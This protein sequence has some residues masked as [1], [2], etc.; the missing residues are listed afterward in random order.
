MNKELQEL[1]TLIKNN[2]SQNFDFC[3][4]LIQILPRYSI[5]TETKRFLKRIL[6]EKITISVTGGEKF[7][8]ESS[9]WEWR[10]ITWGMFT[11]KDLP[12]LVEKMEE[13]RQSIKTRESNR[14]KIIK[15]G[16]NKFL[17]PQKGGS[18]C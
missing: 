7:L 6:V 17:H 4:P 13:R 12:K 14:Q 1:A 2:P 16:I 15:D 5:H 11:E 10:V 9:S 8:A 3:D 18:P